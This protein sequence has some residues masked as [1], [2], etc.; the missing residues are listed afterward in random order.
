M[1]QQSYYGQ[2]WRLMALPLEPNTAI[3]PQPHAR[4]LLLALI[5]EAKAQEETTYQYKVVWYEGNLST[6]EVVDAETIQC[7]VGRVCDNKRWYIIDR[8]SELAHPDI[9]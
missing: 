9:V 5:L 3:N 6:G 4:T 1:V 2:L 7:V 8:S